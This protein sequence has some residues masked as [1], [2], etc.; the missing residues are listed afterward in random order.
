MLEAKVIQSIVDYTRNLNPIYAK[1][2]KYFDASVFRLSINGREVAVKLVKSIDGCSDQL[3]YR[4]HEFLQVLSHQN[5]VKYIDHGV[6]SGDY[7]LI[8]EW[9]NGRNVLEKPAQIGR[10]DKA[11]KGQF[12]DACW[13]IVDHLNNLGIHHRDIWE[14]NIMVCNKQ[15]VLIDFG[16]A[17]WAHEANS[18]T[19]QTLPYRDDV[20]SMRTFIHR[21]MQTGIQ[22]D[23]GGS[24][25]S[26]TVDS[27]GMGVKKEAL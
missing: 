9:I 14:K 25:S 21:S 26:E 23:V 10:M 7:M 16:W 19:T 2:N 24:V 3:L 6:D 8:T 22:S 15:P 1:K 4:E 27:A 20:E 18:G 5:I 13:R 11:E 12:Y 17:C